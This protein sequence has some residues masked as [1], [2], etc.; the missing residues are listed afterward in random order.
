MSDAAIFHPVRR[1]G[2]TAQVTGHLRRRIVSGDLGFNRKLPS[3]ARLAKLYGVSGPTMRT[4]IHELAALGL[5]RIE[6]GVGVYVRRPRTNGAVLDHAWRDATTEELAMVMAALNERLPLMA[7]D[8]V[9]GATNRRVVRDAAELLFH[10]GERSTTRRSWSAEAF[11]E[12][13]LAFH[14]AVARIPP[15]VEGAPTLLD[16]VGH[17]LRPMLMA[18]AQAQAAQGRLDE[19]HLRLAEAIAAGDP[20]RAA[21]AARFVARREARAVT[22]ALG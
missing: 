15:R 22:A 9:R 16:W 7:A 4:A 17:R 21:R 18:T 8:A 5:V 19:G 20:R 10:A 14:R 3:M 1:T 13:D 2:L 6:W 12:A 11:V